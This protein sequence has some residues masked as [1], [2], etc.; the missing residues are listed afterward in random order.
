METGLTEERSSILDLV[1]IFDFVV[2]RHVD[3]FWR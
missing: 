3:F 2:D 1:M